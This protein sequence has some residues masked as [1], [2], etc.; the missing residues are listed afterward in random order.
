MMTIIVVPVQDETNPV[1]VQA[2]FN[3]NPSITLSTIWK[4]GSTFYI[5]YA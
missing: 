2:W 3:A 5:V 4:E 1:E